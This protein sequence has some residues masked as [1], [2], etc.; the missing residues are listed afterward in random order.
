MQEGF[1]APYCS[2]I[3]NKDSTG[4]AE[5]LLDECEGVRHLDELRSD[6]VGQV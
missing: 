3:S 6:A 5:T 1:V 2:G 4:M